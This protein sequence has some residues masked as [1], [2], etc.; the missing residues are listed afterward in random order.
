MLLVMTIGGII[1][2]SIICR[3]RRRPARTG[4]TRTVTT[5]TTKTVYTLGTKKPA[6][7]EKLKRQAEKARKEQFKR[8]QAEQDIIHYNQVKKDLITA[9]DASG[10]VYGDT[11]KA[12][13]KRIQYDN[14]IRR[15][16]KQIEKAA[17]NARH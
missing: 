8:Y 12:I 14:A 15:T 9:Y 6:D 1:V 7:A 5:R 4:P 2:L 10:A 16:E 17:Y 11:E 13:R 3:K